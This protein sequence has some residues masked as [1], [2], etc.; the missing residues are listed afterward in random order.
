MVQCCL[1]CLECIVKFINTQAYIH[2]AIRG[3]NFCYAAKDGFEIAWSNAIRFAVVG[4]VGQVIMFLGKI[5]IGAGTALGFYLLI[6][7]TSIRNSYSQPFYQVILMGL[8]GYLVGTLF[9]SIYAVAMDTLL[10]CFLV[11]E[12]NQ[13]AKGSGKAKYA[14]E[15]LAEVMDVDE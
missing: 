9:M 5:M 8:I 10:Q 11:D 13:K 1:C 15:E 6:N 14:P 4:G 12:A 2:I 3:K 7:Y